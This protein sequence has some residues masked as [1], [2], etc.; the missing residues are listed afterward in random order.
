MLERQ[1]T[2]VH[3]FTKFAAVPKIENDDPSDPPD[4]ETIN[5][6]SGAGNAAASLEIQ[7]FVRCMFNYADSLFTP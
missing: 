6:Q 2:K 4:T 7:N 5:G 1:F 3:K